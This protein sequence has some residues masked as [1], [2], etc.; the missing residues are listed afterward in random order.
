MLKANGDYTDL[1]YG[2]KSINFGVNEN[3]DISI[4]QSIKSSFIEEKPLLTQTQEG[5]TIEFKKSKN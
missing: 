4:N 5:C 1:F 3:P 2:R